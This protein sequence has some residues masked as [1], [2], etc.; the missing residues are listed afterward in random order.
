MS[1]R[2]PAKAKTDGKTEPTPFQPI[3]S[4]VGSTEKAADGRTIIVTERG[5]GAVE[6]A[7]AAGVGIAGIAALLGISREALRRVR[8]RQPEL[9]EALSR[10]NA[11]NEAELVSLLMEQ[12]RNGAFVPAMF[13]LK[14]KHGYREGDAPEQRPNVVINLPGALGMQQ[15][16][17]ALATRTQPAIEQSGN[18]PALGVKGVQR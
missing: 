2:V 16:L 6:A 3:R 8:E 11:N 1:K 17:E 15:Y 7:A 13:L 14:T 4:V 12:A 9:D 5:I 18:V 10:G